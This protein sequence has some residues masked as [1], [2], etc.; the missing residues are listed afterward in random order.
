MTNKNRKILL[1]L[2]FFAISFIMWFLISL[3]EYYNTKIKLPIDITGLPANKFVKSEDTKAINLTV[4]GYGYDIIKYSL[5]N[6][7]TTLKI[8]LNKVKLHPL[9]EKDTNDYFF[10]TKD[11]ILQLSSQLS[12]KIKIIS[13]SPD[14]VHIT[15]SEMVAKHIQI[16]PDV[17][18]TFAKQYINKTPIRIEP[19]KALVKGPSYIIDTLQYIKTEHIEFNNLD[20]SLKQQ[21]KILVPKNV[22][23]VPK[24][25]TLFI[26]V[27][28]YTEDRMTIPIKIINLPQNYNLIL[29]P[30]KVFIRFNVGIDNYNKIRPE[31][32]TA[33]VDYND[34]VDAMSDEIP[35]KIIHKPPKIYS[36][37]Y[38]PHAVEYILEQK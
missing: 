12:P 18:I 19:D 30:N 20:H 22:V 21:I 36:F 33:I 34:I 24:T 15:F 23:A 37:T 7:I 3:D 1:F 8:N 25:T 2:I 14:T 10:L 11:I 9:R 26:E 31:H 16:K 28:Q 35:V 4:N 27:E 6:K 5:V 38:Y 17:N 13:I 29:F 32:F